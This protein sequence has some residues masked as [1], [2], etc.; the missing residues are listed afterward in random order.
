MGDP[1]GREGTGGPTGDPGT[2]QPRSSLGKGTAPAPRPQQKLRDP[3]TGCC[4]RYEM[5][6]RFKSHL[7]D[8]GLVMPSNLS[9]VDLFQSLGGRGNLKESWRW[10]EPKP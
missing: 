6:R 8:L 5:Q 1:W 4:L 10:W 7:W 3:R 2:R 9:Y